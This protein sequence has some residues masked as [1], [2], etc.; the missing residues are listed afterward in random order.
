MKIKSLLLFLT[1]TFI[2]LANLIAQ[3][4][5]PKDYF[6]SPLNINLSL[7]GSFSEIRPNHL[8]SG[9]DLS[10]QG[11]EGLPV[12]AVADG[13]IS[14]IKVSPIGFGNALYI[15]H[16]NGFTSVYGHMQRYNDTITAYLRTNQYKL[17][18]FAVDLFPSNKKD[19][20]YVKRYFLALT[21]LISI[22]LTLILLNFTLKIIT[23]SLVPRMMLPVLI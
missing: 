11:R 22:R 13:V 15:N 10:V 3:I 18:S 14:R 23:V 12:F 21:F 8:H 7:T 2:S 16:P 5:I 6:S 20:I 19:L 17:K 4:A 1:L 9:T